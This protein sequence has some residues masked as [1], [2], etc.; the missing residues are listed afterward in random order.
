VPARKQAS[1]AKGKK[2]MLNKDF[3][4]YNALIQLDKN[5]VILD[6][7]LFNIIN[8]HN[9][10]SAKVKQQGEVID[11]LIEGLNNANIANE[12]LLAELSSSIMDK[13]NLGK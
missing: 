10:L 5:V 13:L 8:R 11:V 9:E 4:P 3:D 2:K 7:N 12:V 6:Q 1:S